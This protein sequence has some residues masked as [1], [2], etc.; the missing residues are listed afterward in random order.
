SP[1][2]HWET[3]MRHLGDSNTRRMVFVSLYLACRSFRLHLPAE[4]QALIAADPYVLEIADY[5]CQDLWPRTEVEPSHEAPLGWPMWRSRG[6]HLRDRARYVGGIAFIPTLID[7]QTFKLPRAF[8]SLYPWLRAGRLALK[9][10]SK[11]N[12]RS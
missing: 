11:K 2:L 12:R 5:V 8:V 3:A 6:E 9:Y 1:S 7:F 10:G 4:I